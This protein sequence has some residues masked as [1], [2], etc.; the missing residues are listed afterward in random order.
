M[1][2]SVKCTSYPASY[3]YLVGSAWHPVGLTSDL[4]ATP[5]CVSLPLWW[6]LLLWRLSAP[7]N[8]ID[9]HLR[10]PGVEGSVLSW[11]P[12]ENWYKIEDV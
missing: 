8:G 11:L 4:L 9:S 7:P 1:V 6:H 5:M 12:A 2:Q 10:S 3:P